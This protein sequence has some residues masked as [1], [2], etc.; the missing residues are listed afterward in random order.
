MDTNMETT[1]VGWQYLCTRWS[2]AKCHLITLTNHRKNTVC[3]WIIRTH[4]AEYVLRY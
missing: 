2:H 1:S 4:R 3:S